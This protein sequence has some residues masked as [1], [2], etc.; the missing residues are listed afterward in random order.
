VRG[1]IVKAGGKTPAI[2][3]AITSIGLSS[4]ISYVLQEKNIMQLRK[5]IAIDSIL[6]IF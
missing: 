4:F 6:I 3:S 5:L 1:C 2:E